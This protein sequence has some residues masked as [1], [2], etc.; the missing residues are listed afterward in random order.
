MTTSWPAAE[1]RVVITGVGPI[2]AIGTG[3][4]ELWN[5][6]L[7]GRSGVVLKQ[8]EFGGAAC[9]SFPIAAVP[10]FSAEAIGLPLGRFRTL[11]QD[12]AGDDVDFH[13]LAAASHLALKDSGLR[14]DPDDNRV[15]LVLTHENP[16]MD[17]Y[18]GKVLETA[19]LLSNGRQ[20]GAREPKALFAELYREHSP[21]VYGTH[22]F[23]YLHWVARVL[24]IHG[25]SLFINNACASGL[26]AIEAAALM[27]RSGQAEA[28]VVAGADH[29]MSITKY[30]WFDGLGLYARD[31]LMRPFDDRRSGLILGDGAAAVVLED[32]QTARGRGARIYAEYLG[33]GFNQEAWKVTMPS[34]SG[35]YCARAF[36]D[37]LERTGVE[38][39]E[40]DVVN[41]HGTATTLWDAYEARALTSIFGKGFEKPL[42]TAL[43]PYVGH[44]LGA[45][46][47]TE[48]VIL[49]LAMEA[50]LVPPTLNCERPDPKLGVR[51]VREAV[52]ASLRTVV[53]MSSGF[54]GFNA[55]GVFRKLEAEAAGPRTPAPVGADP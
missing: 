55:V 3:R 2:T 20:T 24:G 22:S 33:G 7:A 53:K 35:D 8:Q 16:G 10:A 44:M 45:S 30:L 18:V 31:G 39:T 15:A 23:L 41:P 52:R 21:Y 29:P 40:V 37:A 32:L 47:L 25:P 42:I 5:S 50:D 51:P 49:L 26:Y 36:R 38:P 46:A 28:A 6:V 4:N 11:T 14:H 27:I 19:R 43:K 9:G 13:Y 34:I 48:V 17:R 54:G 12:G 1:R